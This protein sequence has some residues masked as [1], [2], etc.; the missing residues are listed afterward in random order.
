MVVAAET[1]SGKTHAYLIPLIEK[2]YNL[3]DGREGF[4]SDEELKLSL[5]FCH[6]VLL[7]EQLVQMACGLLD[8]VMAS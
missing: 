5:V 4:A 1:G 6:N 3:S 7:C 8:A 2:L